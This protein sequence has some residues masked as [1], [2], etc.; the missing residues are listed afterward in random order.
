KLVGYNKQ[1][2]S[3]LPIYKR[4]GIYSGSSGYTWWG[5]YSLEKPYLPNR[6][7]TYD[8]L[9]VYNNNINY[10][11]NDTL[12]TENVMNF[13]KV[14]DGSV[15]NGV[16]Q[17]ETWRAYVPEYDNTLNASLPR[18]PA[19]TAQGVT[20]YNGREYWYNNYDDYCYISMK[21]RGVD[22]EFIIYFADYDDD[23]TT[24][25]YDEGGDTSKRLDILRNNIYRFYVQQSNGSL[26]VTV[27][28]WENEYDNSYD[29]GRN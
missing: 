27:D 21:L 15:D 11:S 26:A 24:T 6:S 14:Q 4:R 17:Y 10:R 25:A 5:N 16:I 2:Y 7:F 1:G 29:F 19:Q 13:A 9:G 3:G 22:E 28:K 8:Y 12:S 20:N 18:E 23:G